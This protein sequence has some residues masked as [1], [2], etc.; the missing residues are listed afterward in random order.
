MEIAR[1]SRM[2]R[3]KIMSGPEQ[4]KQYAH[5]IMYQFWS[6]SRSI[7]VLW[8][9]VFRM[10]SSHVFAFATVVHQASHYSA[11]AFH[12]HRYSFVDTAPISAS[13][14]LWSEA[15]HFDA[16]LFNARPSRRCRQNIK[17]GRSGS[18]RTSPDTTGVQP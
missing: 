1:S 18:I 2:R 5:G 12:R 14:S 6:C 7:V 3:D 13:H 17:H 8:C 11:F 15:R 4:R 10:P 16:S 9:L